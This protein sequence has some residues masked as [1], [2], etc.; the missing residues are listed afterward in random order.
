MCTW[1]H[2]ESIL[3]KNIYLEILDLQAA[4]AAYNLKPIRSAQL[5]LEFSPGHTEWNPPCLSYFSPPF[6]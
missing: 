4:Q 5:H 6:C 1:L 3:Y 2:L